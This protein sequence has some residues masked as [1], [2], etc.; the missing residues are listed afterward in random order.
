MGIPMTSK[1]PKHSSTKQSPILNN[2]PIYYGIQSCMRP[3]ETRSYG[4]ENLSK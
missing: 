2:H 1:S 4:W 3:L